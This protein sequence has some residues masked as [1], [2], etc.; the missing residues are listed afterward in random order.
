MDHHKNSASNTWQTRIYI[1]AKFPK[2][3][4]EKHSVSVVKPPEHSFSPQVSEW[5]V[6]GQNF[7]ALQA[8][9]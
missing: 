3:H 2:L 7:C 6:G 4:H 9:R 5:S 8:L 1:V